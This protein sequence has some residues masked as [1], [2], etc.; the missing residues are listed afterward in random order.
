MTGWSLSHETRQRDTRGDL[1][2]VLQTCRSDL[3]PSPRLR[4]TPNLRH[5]VILP[6]RICYPTRYGGVGSQALAPYLRVGQFNVKSF[7]FLHCKRLHFFG[8]VRAGRQAQKHWDPGKAVW[9]SASL[10]FWQTL[11]PLS[12]SLS[13]ISSQSFQTL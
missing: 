4:P 2:T 12:R 8:P 5:L 7:F 1:R 13:F 11:R 3:I 6:H 9:G 10:C